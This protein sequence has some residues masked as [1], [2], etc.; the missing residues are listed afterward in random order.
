MKIGM[1]CH[2]LALIASTRLFNGGKHFW[3]WRRTRGQW[4]GVTLGEGHFG[5]K[6]LDVN[7]PFLE[8]RGRIFFR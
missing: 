2:D 6:L 8:T 5:P 1:K 7:V 4:R 3:Y